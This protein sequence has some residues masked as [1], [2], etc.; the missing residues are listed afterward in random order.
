MQVDY[1]EHPNRWLNLPFFPIKFI[2]AIPHL[3][4]LYVIGIIALLLVFIAQIAILFTGSFPAGLHTFVVG[5]Q[6]WTARVIAYLA[7]F[8][9]KYPPFSLN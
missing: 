5:Y 8:T 1:P 4:I 9:D 2:L 7:A 6:R 3:A